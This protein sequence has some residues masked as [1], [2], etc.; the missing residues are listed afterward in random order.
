[1]KILLTGATGFIGRHLLEAL[2]KA[3]GRG[4]VVAVSSSRID[5][6]DHFEE[7]NCGGLFPSESILRAGHRDV[8]CI[9]HLG[10]FTPKESKEADYAK[11]A[12]GN[13]LFTDS[14]LR[15]NF[16]FLVK[17]IFIS[18]LD[19]YGLYSGVIS[20]D[21]PICPLNLY[22]QSKVFCERMVSSFFANKDVDFAILRL[23]HVYGPGEERY[24]KIIP[25]A[26]SNILAGRTVTLFGDGEEKRSFIYV[27][28]VVSSIMAALAARMSGKIINVVGG[29]TVSINELIVRIA[30][31]SGHRAD[32]RYMNVAKYRH[33]SIFDNSRLHKLLLP[34]GETVL[35]EGLLH[36]IQYIES[37]LKG[38]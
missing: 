37:Q 5:Y 14:L 20:E 21:T 38:K 11:G 35:D 16:P 13:I 3:Y 34:G 33:D 26:I 2:R 15:T 30:E 29:T 7:Y 23:G 24:K 9:V 32:I 28:D 22:S 27:K 8:D 18:T 4:A 10:A 19:V 6:G 31:L 17:F 12:I 1:M 36:E 25:V